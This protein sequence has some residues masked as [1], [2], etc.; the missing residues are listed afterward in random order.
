[1]DATRPA[2]DEGG[3]PVLE[4]GDPLAELLGALPPG[5]RF[6]Y[7][8]DDAVK[9]AGH[10]CPT[11]AG[12]WRM[13][14]AALAALYRPGELPRRGEL[15]VTVGGTSDD[16]ASG[17][18]AA[19]IGLV[20]GAAAEGGF[21]GLLGR[22]ARRGLLRFDAALAGRVRFRRRDG[23][24]AVA[25]SFDP[26]PVPAA[27]ETGRLLAACLDGRGSESERARLAAC[28]QGRVRELLRSER[29]GVVRV[30]RTSE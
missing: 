4:L 29:P 15:E 18:V 25:V 28:W 10:S 23:G 8:Y 1:M 24:G 21:G 19:V 16:G 11:V 9:L 22:H 13:V 27:P 17:P 2:V 14:A 12:A 26:A 30:E 5:G 20:T 7:T 3:A 6:R